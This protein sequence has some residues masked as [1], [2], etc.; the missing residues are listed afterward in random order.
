MEFLEINEV[1]DL[2]YVKWI[3]PEKFFGGL[4]I[5]LAGKAQ[6]LVFTGGKMPLDKAKKTEG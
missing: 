3:D 6:K 4:A 5:F 2:T 1:G